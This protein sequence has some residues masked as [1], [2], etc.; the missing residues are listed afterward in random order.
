MLSGFG[1]FKINHTNSCHLLPETCFTNSKFQSMDFKGNSMFTGMVMV[2][3]LKTAGGQQPAS[4]SKNII[5][6]ILAH[7]SHEAHKVIYSNGILHRLSIHRP[8]FS[9]IFSEAAQPIKFKIYI[10]NR[11]EESM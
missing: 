4:T 6:C 10:K 8:P 2:V 3:L 11:K 1:N 9:E 5:V 7:L